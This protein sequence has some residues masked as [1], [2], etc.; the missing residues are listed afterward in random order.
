MLF[1]SIFF[2]VAS[3]A[4]HSS[5]FLDQTLPFAKRRIALSLLLSGGLGLAGLALGLLLLVLGVEVL[6][7]DDSDGDLIGGGTAGS[8]D[9]AGGLNLLDG[10]HSLVLEHLGDGDGVGDGSA[11]SAELNEGLTVVQQVLGDVGI[12]E[13]ALGG[14][15]ADVVLLL[16]VILS[17]LSGL[18]V[19]SG[20]CEVLSWS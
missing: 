3:C 9:T 19:T 20:H 5:H 6:G 11:K 1:F 10:D 13:L 14:A 7:L 2:L 4:L 17:L 18:V 15:D 8:D 12:H 16:V